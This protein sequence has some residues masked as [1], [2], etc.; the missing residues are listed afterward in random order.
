MCDL[1]SCCPQDLKKEIARHLHKLYYTTVMEELT[2]LTYPIQV[3][4][5][6]EHVTLLKIGLTTLVG[7]VGDDFIC[8][9]RW[10]AL[11]ADEIQQQQYFNLFDMKRRG[12]SESTCF[13]HCSAYSIAL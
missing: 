5:K 6:L 12:N 9:P 13:F 10:D 4:L 7:V 8:L 2:L 11:I 3:S 1:F